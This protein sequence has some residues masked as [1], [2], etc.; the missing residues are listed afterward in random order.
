MKNM[1]IRLRRRWA[2][3]SLLS[4]LLTA[5]VAIAMPG[6]A[7]AASGSV[8]ARPSACETRWVSTSS[9]WVGSGYVKLRST[10]SWC[11]NKSR[12]YDPRPGY[13]QVISGSADV[14]QTSSNIGYYN[15]AGQGAYSGYQVQRYFKACAPSGSNTTCVYPNIRIFV[16]RDGSLNWYTK[17]S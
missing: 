15:Y 7:H 2:L 14:S 12:V 10:M 17:N 9:I 5:G 3:T 1:S 4:V 13:W 6:A 11:W 8:G 16:H